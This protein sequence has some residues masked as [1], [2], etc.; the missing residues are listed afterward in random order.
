M[1]CTLN[2]LSGSTDVKDDMLKPSHHRTWASAALIHCFG[3]MATK[4]KHARLASPHA[5]YQGVDKGRPVPVISF[6]HLIAM[7]IGSAWHCCPFHWHFACMTTWCSR[8][9]RLLGSF[10]LDLPPEAL[11]CWMLWLG[12]CDICL[13]ATAKPWICV[14]LSEPLITHVM[15]SLQ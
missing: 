10:S 6:R 2:L 14:L 9:N 13:S 11:L 12:P 3:P 5:G 7:D 8:C 4:S 15:I 1:S